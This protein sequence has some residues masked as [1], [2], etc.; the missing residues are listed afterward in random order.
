V[1]TEKFERKY[2]PNQQLSLANTRRVR[3][4]RR[5][6]EI[7]TLNY[8]LSVGTGASVMDRAAVASLLSRF[9]LDLL[10]HFDD[11]FPLSADDL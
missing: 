8:T 9:I 4:R 2:L 1:K 5:I 7:L 6:S 11:H 10:P 3:L